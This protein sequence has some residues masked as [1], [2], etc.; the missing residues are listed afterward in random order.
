MK[1]KKYV[2]KI[3][4]YLKVFI[5]TQNLEKLFF[6]FNTLKLKKL[7]IFSS[8]FFLYGIITFSYSKNPLAC[9]YFCFT[10]KYPTKKTN[11]IQSCHFWNAAVRVTGIA[12]SHKY[13]EF[14]QCYEMQRQSGLTCW[15]LETSQQHIKCF[16]MSSK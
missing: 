6:I 3:N 14:W 11:I 5:S 7:I 4:F 15:R 1:F 12:N 10:S 2:Q 16:Y 9:F 8:V 13:V